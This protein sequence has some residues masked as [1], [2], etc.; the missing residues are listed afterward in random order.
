MSSRPS[1][2]AFSRL[3]IIHIVVPLLALARASVPLVLVPETLVGLP[4]FD[5]GISLLGDAALVAAGGG[6]G[7]SHVRVTRPSASS[8]GFLQ[9]PKSFRFADPRSAAPTSF[10]SEFAFSI[11]PGN[12]DGLA[13][14]LFP[15]DFRVGAEAF[16]LSGDR[17][18]VAVEYD[19]WMNEEVGDVNANHVGVDLG[20]FRS[21][22]VCNASSVGLALS[23]G[24]KLKSWVD[25]DGSSK[26]LEVRLSKFRDPRPY[27]PIIAYSIDL[28]RMWKGEDVYVGI[29]SANGNSS[30]TISVYS[31]RFKPRKIPMSMHS[32]PARPHGYSSE[33]GKLRKRG[34][35]PL[36]ILGRVIFATGCGALLAFLGLFLWAIVANRHTVFPAECP[37]HPAD[38]KY[39]K[40]NVV[41]GKDVEGGKH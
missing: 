13:L 35:C 21:V 7:G 31:W 27:D 5:D 33:H 36:A 10:S 29:S 23:S 38:F 1:A 40:I 11:S 20:N 8:S 3:L 26:R 39:E 16:G 15:R 12:A 6:G 17:R 37:V 25:Y 22:S 24:E 2:L 34:N 41:A 18:F 32:L 19:A 28:L 30:Q 14:V 9:W 4:G